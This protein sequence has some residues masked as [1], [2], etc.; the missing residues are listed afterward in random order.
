M[1]TVIYLSSLHSC[2]TH[3]WV[4]CRTAMFSAYYVDSLRP[5]CSSCQ[6]VRQKTCTVNTSIPARAKVTSVGGL[7]I[8]T[9][10][11]KHIECTTVYV[12]VSSPLMMSWQI[13]RVCLFLSVSAQ[14]LQ[15]LSVNPRVD[16][17]DKRLAQRNKCKYRSYLW[18]ANVSQILLP[19]SKYIGCCATKTK[20]CT[21][22]GNNYRTKTMD[23]VHK[24]S[25]L[26]PALYRH[27]KRTAVG[28]TFALS[29]VQVSHIK[30]D[31]SS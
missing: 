11:R 5:E 3:W 17:S 22:E 29:Y 15:K 12:T 1:N 31:F 19:Y 4:Y 16:P 9:C 28:C 21:Y 6:S 23:I 14:Q 2:K 18:P 13:L 27:N 7:D 10:T 30:H 20:I 24:Q 25:L 26:I 8:C